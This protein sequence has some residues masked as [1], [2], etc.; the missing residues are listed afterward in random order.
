MHAALYLACGSTE[1]AMRFPR[2]RVTIAGA[3]ASH[4]TRGTRADAC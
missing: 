4:K 1:P 3:R 2:M